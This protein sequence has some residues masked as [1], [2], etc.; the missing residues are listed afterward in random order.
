MR[1]RLASRVCLAALVSALTAAAAGGGVRP[2]RS[3]PLGTVGGGTARKLSSIVIPRIEFDNAPLLEVLRF[4]QRES[5]R[6][7]PDHLGINFLILLDREA[8]RYDHFRVTMTLRRIP[9]GEVLRYL[10][11]ATG[12]PYRV[13]EHAVLVAGAGSPLP[14]MQ[15]RY[16]GM[17]PGILNTPRT[18][19]FQPLDLDDDD[20]D[21]DAH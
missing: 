21:D 14:R 20:D 15:T 6:L 19:N 1:W 17:E 13:E 11:M 10:S 7:D 16:Y 12:V 2:D 4:L 3:W 18:F 9:L 5:V 8:A